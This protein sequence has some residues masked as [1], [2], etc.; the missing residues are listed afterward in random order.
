[1]PLLPDE[2]LLERAIG[3]AIALAFSLG[4]LDPV[5][6]GS[7]YF[8]PTDEPAA[9]RPAVRCFW[10]AQVQL[11]RDATHPVAQRQKWKVT[12]DEVAA[13]EYTVS[14]RKAPYV[15]PAGPGDDA[16][17]IQAGLLAALAA[18]PDATPTAGDVDEELFVE[19]VDAGVHLALT[20]E[21]HLSREI[22]RDRAAWQTAAP[23]ERTLSIQVAAEIDPAAPSPKQ[24]ALAYASLLRA[25]LG[26]PDV[27]AR[28]RQAGV[29]VRRIAAGPIGGLD[30]LNGTV[31]ETRASLEVVL[32][33]TAGA[34][35]GAGVMESASL[36]ATNIAMEHPP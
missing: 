5:A 24:T 32:S 15:Y 20:V 16:A 19:A 8:A 7:V 2:V 34:Q 13:S 17:A 36:T 6:E 10:G 30:V 25:R 31:T 26:H 18:T 27:Q 35:H 14:V 9:P 29:A 21:G 1:M 28:L 23:A 33:I 22:V 12:I 3:E 4:D 11:G